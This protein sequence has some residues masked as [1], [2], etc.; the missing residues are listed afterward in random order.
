MACDNEVITVIIIK[1]CSVSHLSEEP[2]QSLIVII[3]NEIIKYGNCHPD[4][5][6]GNWISNRDTGDWAHEN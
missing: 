3:T 1:R 6:T 4:R 5:D 2:L